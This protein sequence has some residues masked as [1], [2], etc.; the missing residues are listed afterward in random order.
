MDLKAQISAL[1]QKNKEMSKAESEAGDVGALVTEV[2]I[3]HIVAAW[4]GIPVDKDGR[5][6]DSKERTVDF[7]NTLLI[8]T[9]K[10]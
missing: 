10:P 9:S 3:Q 4:T 7:K 8:M 6:T 1:I 2:D 5:L